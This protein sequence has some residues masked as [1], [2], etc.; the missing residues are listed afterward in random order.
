MDILKADPS[1]AVP[2]EFC[3]LFIIF[4]YILFLQTFPDAVQ[5]VLWNTDPIILHVL[6]QH[7]M[8]DINSDA[9]RTVLLFFRKTM[10][11]YVLNN[12]LK[13]QL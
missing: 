6:Y 10:K 2:S 8:A 9:N 1:S 4:N 3:V 13:N 7:A 5:F 11:N 12:R